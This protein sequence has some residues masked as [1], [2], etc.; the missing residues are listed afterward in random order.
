MVEVLGGV[1]GISLREERRVRR[2]RPRNVFWM[3][4]GVALLLLNRE[5]G[6]EGGS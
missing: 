1:C 4:P 5:E 6:G 3:L 2:R